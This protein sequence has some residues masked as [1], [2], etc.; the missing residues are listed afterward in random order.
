MQAMCLL[1][2]III[3]QQ[4]DDDN[5]EGVDDSE[6]AAALGHLGDGAGKVITGHGAGDAVVAQ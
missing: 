3:Q 5:D 1:G 2:W 6:L 4:Q